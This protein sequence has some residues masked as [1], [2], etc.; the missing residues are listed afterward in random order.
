MTR[1]RFLQTTAG[2]AGLVLPVA[3]M[4]SSCAQQQKNDA[5]GGVDIGAISYS[6]RATP[7]NSDAE[8][9]LSYLTT[10]G[11]TTVELM[12][13]T[14][15]SFAGA[16]SPPP[17]PRRRD[18][19][20]EERAAF[21]EQREAAQ[22]E[23]NQWRLSAPMEKYVELGQ[24]YKDA[25]VTIDIL[26][27]G[28]WRWPD[29]LIDYAFN[30]AKAVGARG[31]CF[32]VNDEGAERIAP[33]ADKHQAIVG[34]HHHLQVADE[35][36]S[37]DI[38]LSFS[39]NNMINFDVGHYFA[40]T[41]ES[42]VLF[43]E[44]YHSRISHLHLK[45]RKFSGEKENLPWGEGETPLVEILQLLKREQYPIPAMIELEYEIPEDSDPVAEVTKCVEYCRE[46]LA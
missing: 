25:G 19:S 23:A 13:N 44:R 21:M 34:L 41:G 2:A 22:Q 20:D 4:N 35:G 10:C 8:L 39:T 12:G 28:D 45:D 37:W 29:E 6:F 40:A 24:M 16:P 11:L 27:L 7:A 32:E 33:F 30:A 38:P 9:M 31:I 42:P 5:F 26:K 3:A 36:F 18:M 1:R 46:A 14:A 17:F 43:I 15:E